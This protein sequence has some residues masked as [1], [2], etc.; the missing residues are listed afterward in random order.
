MLL[1][2]AACALR[3]SNRP[4]SEIQLKKKKF[5]FNRLATDIQYFGQKGII[6]CVVEVMILKWKNNREEDVISRDF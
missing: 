5:A 3:F 4:T 1:K 6:H 2:F